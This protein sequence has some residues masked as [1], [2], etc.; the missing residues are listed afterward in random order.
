MFS[1][2][3]RMYPNRGL[4]RIKPSVCPVSLSKRSMTHTPSKIW[5]A[6]TSKTLAFNNLDL[7][8][9]SSWHL[10]TG[11]ATELNQVKRKP[12]RD[13]YLCQWPQDPLPEGC[14][15]LSSNRALCAPQARA[16]RQGFSPSTL[17]K[18]SPSGGPG[19]LL[20]CSSEAPP[21]IGAELFP[22]QKSGKWILSRQLAFSPAGW[23][24]AACG[25]LV[26]PL[27]IASGPQP[28]TKSKSVAHQ[29]IP[30]ISILC[31]GG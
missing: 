3:Q 7:Q 24:L 22:W 31:Q 6:P 23:C 30:A 17:V 28:I 20:S 10:D 19:W 25:I 5:S 26:P 1:K 16:T 8:L 18:E 13:N 15:F 27:G 4:G 2:D 29:G 11:H 9:N 12:R 14:I 21:S